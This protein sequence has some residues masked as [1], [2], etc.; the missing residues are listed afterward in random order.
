MKRI[1]TAYEVRFRALLA[2]MGARRLERGVQWL[3]I[4]AEQHSAREGIPLATALNRLYLTLLRRAETRLTR[5]TLLTAISAVPAAGIQTRRTPGPSLFFCDAGLGGLARWLRAAGYDTA[6]IADISDA[7]LLREAQTRGALIIT[8][9]S[10][11][12][13]RRLLRDGAIPA[14][15]LPPT[16]TVLEQLAL[17]F[18]ELRLTVRE[19]R[20]MSCGGELRRVEKEIM[21]DRIPP[22]TWRWVDQYFLCSRCDKLFWHGTHWERIQTRLRQL[23]GNK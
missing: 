14:L 19:P 12:L 8:T 10:M 23:E 18:Q 6:W 16:L 5:P 7:D 17:V 11:L 13:E 15:W 22:K 1:R 3:L 2:Q 4:K 21:R 9:D 20:C